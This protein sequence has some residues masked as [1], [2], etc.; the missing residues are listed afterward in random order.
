MSARA[1][2]EG[3]NLYIKTESGGRTNEVLIRK[4]EIVP[5]CVLDKSVAFYGASGSGKSSTIKCFLKAMKNDFCVAKLYSTTNKETGDFTGPIDEMFTFD[6]P[7]LES[8]KG[9]LDYAKYRTDLYNK[10]NKIENIRALYELL[11][12]SK[13]ESD[14]AQL[15][16]DTKAA[17]DEAAGNEL[18]I[19][20]IQKELQ[21]AV[22]KYMKDVIVAESGKA[23]N[24]QLSPELQTT[25]LCHN[26]NP[27][28]LLIMDDSSPEIAALCKQGKKMAEKASAASGEIKTENDVMR[29]ITQR[30][31]WFHITYF[32][33]A[34]NC[35]TIEKEV[36]SNIHISIFCTHEFAMHF[37]R[38]E[39]L[40]ERLVSDVIDVLSDEN[41]MGTKY[42]RLGYDR[43]TSSFFYVTPTEAGNDFQVGVSSVQAFASSLPKKETETSAFTNDYKLIGL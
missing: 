26:I 25:L 6:A 13:H 22:T 43:T 21:K 10:A 41:F 30:G 1:R 32:L 9:D 14:M 24:L 20:R 4:K 18:E 23:K 5:R 31:R 2:F 42:A 15:A 39:S 38:M 36:R 28:T 3:T 27:Y 37:A 12:T 16:A 8:V 17:L 11:K 29:N 35:T 33:A 34:H 40:D 19:A 7:T